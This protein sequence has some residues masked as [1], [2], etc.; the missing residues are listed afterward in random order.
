MQWPWFPVSAG[1]RGHTHIPSGAFHCY[2]QPTYLS[3]F[4]SFNYRWQCVE[5]PSNSHN[6]TQ[7][8]Q[9]DPVIPFTLATGAALIP[10]HISW[11]LQLQCAKA[12]VAVVSKEPPI[13]CTA[14]TQSQFPDTLPSCTLAP[15]TQSL[16]IAPKA[17]LVHDKCGAIN[18][19]WREQPSVMWKQ[20]ISL[21]T[22]H[23]QKWIQ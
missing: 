11:M 1:A 6:Y 2:S 12:I 14:E 15:A 4:L 5:P 3:P 20:L 22:N 13:R 17:F 23:R 16:R 8:L 19:W 18:Q 21:I 7:F 9:I 10:A